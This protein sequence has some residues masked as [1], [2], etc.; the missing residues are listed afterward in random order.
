MS[1]NLKTNLV[2]MIVLHKHKIARGKRGVYIYLLR[3][4]TRTVAI[5]FECLISCE[6]LE[7]IK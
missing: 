4:D 7:D 5:S 2:A 3:K 1:L 6:Q